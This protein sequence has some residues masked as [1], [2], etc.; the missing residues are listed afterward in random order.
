MMPYIHVEHSQLVPDSITAA[1]FTG[2]PWRFLSIPDWVR[3]RNPK[4]QLHWISWAVRNHYRDNRGKLFLFG[5]IVGYRV[6][7]PEHSL[8]FD[9]N[10]RYL[11]TRHGEF[12]PGSGSISLRRRR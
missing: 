5:H 12:I 4:A 7:Y 11:E 10:G 1:A 9:I 3:R 8:M 6:V 2:A